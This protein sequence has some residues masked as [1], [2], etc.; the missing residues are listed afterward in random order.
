M[1]ATEAE[2][3]K[4]EAATATRVSDLLVD[5]FR[6]PD[7][8]I[9][10]GRTITAR[11]LVDAA[12]ERVNRELGDEPIVRARLLAA[13]G[14]SYHSLGLFDEAVTVHETALG[15]L[16]AN[17]TDTE[18]IADVE[19][20]R[21]ESLRR[22]GRLEP[23]REAYKN[24]IR[25]MGERHG[26][27]DPHVLNML[28]GLADI[29]L[30]EGDSAAA[31]PIMADVVERMR[32]QGDHREGLVAALNSLS[33]L[34]CSVGRG[35]EAI[36]LMREAIAAQTLVAPEGSLVTAK[37]QANLAW[38]LVQTDALDEAE[39]L[40]LAAQVYRERVLPPG[41]PDFASSSQTL[42]TIY[43]KRDRANDAEPPLRAAVALRE[44]YASSREDPDLAEC[45]M[46]LGDCL[47]RIDRW[48]EGSALLES[49]CD[50]LL[51][52]PEPLVDA[53]IPAIARMAEHIDASAEPGERER[54]T[55]RLKAAEARADAGTSLPEAISE[56]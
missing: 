49:G 19:L 42:G 2:R 14:D 9:G 29:V 51:R 8:D 45:R 10:R 41:H 52:R 5:M 30:Q 36:P 34:L 40:V 13:L 26:M 38:L 4:T 53:L 23:A 54:W 43:L 22:L 48:A 37:L 56:N 27:D 16:R 20:S 1:A 46:L 44:R 15:L 21:A 31:I 7:P 18:R 35:R 32:Q 24:A 6:I 11:Q 28:R 50:A 17:D 33:G 25:I 39:P 55:Q 3:A 47:C 12:V